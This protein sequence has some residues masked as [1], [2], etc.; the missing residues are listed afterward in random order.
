GLFALAAAEGCHKKFASTFED[1]RHCFDAVPSD[2]GLG[3]G[4]DYGDTHIIPIWSSLTVVGKPVV[5]ACRLGG[6]TAGTTLVNQHAYEELSTRFSEYCDFEETTIDVKNEGK[7][8]AYRAHLR[9]GWA[10]DC[11]LPIWTKGAG[12]S[13]H[14]GLNDEQGNSAS[15]EV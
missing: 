14:E 9:S 13:P 5:Y 1:H 2:A 11:N 6:A 3:I 15:E 4:I 8:V 7:M 10:L 12:E